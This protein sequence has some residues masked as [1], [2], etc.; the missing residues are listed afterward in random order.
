ML[1]SN[2]LN[3]NKE[4]FE[5]RYKEF[6]QYYQLGIPHYQDLAK[7]RLNNL[8]EKTEKRE[9]SLSG[10]LRFM[11]DIKDQTKFFT[12]SKMK[13]SR[14]LIGGR[15]DKNDRVYLK[16][17]GFSVDISGLWNSNIKIT[18]EKEYQK[19]LDKFGDDA[20]SSTKKD[21]VK[22]NKNMLDWKSLD[23]Y[24]D[25][26]GSVKSIVEFFFNMMMCYNSSVI[27]NSD[28]DWQ[29][30]ASS[31]WYVPLPQEWIK[32]K[33]ILDQMMDSSGNVLDNLKNW[34]IP[35]GGIVGNKIK[36]K[37][38]GIDGKPVTD[39]EQD[40]GY[41]AA[42]A[43]KLNLYN[44]KLP[45]WS[46]AQITDETNKAYYGGAFFTPFPVP[47]KLGNFGYSYADK[48]I[49]NLVAQIQNTQGAGGT[50][51]FF[52]I[53]P[54][55]S[56]GETGNTYLSGYYG[57]RYRTI[58]DI[59]YSNAF[60]TSL[61]NNFI[62]SGGP[63]LH[64]AY[65]SASGPGQTT[66]LRKNEIGG[67][68]SV[69][70]FIPLLDTNKPEYNDYN[71][72]KY[73]I[74]GDSTNRTNFWYSTARNAY[75]TL[76]L[77]T[78]LSQPIGSDENDYEDAIKDNNI[79]EIGDD[80]LRYTKER[81]IANPTAGGPMSNVFT[82]SS[83]AKNIG[84][85]RDM[86]MTFLLSN[87]GGYEK[88]YNQP[89]L[90]PPGLLRCRGV[91]KVTN[92]DI[93][94]IKDNTPYGDTI[95]SE[96]AIIAIV[97]RFAEIIADK[98]KNYKNI[99]KN[100]WKD[101]FTYRLS[102]AILMVRKTLFEA[103]IMK[104]FLRDGK[105]L[106]QFERMYAKQPNSNKKTKNGFG[107]LV[108]GQ[109]GPGKVSSQLWGGRGCVSKTY[110]GLSNRDDYSDRFTGCKGQPLTL[111][112]TNEFR[113]AFKEMINKAICARFLH[114][115]EPK[116][117]DS[118]EVPEKYWK[119]DKFVAW[120]QGDCDRLVKLDVSSILDIRIL[121]EQGSELFNMHEYLRNALDSEFNLNQYNF[122]DAEAK[123][124]RCTAGLLQADPDN[125]ITF[126]KLQVYLKKAH[127]SK[128]VL[129][130]QIDRTEKKVK[131]E[132]KAEKLKL[133][134]EITGQVEELLRTSVDGL[135]Q[136]D[137]DK[138]QKGLRSV[139][140]LFFTK[141][142]K[143][144]SAYR[145]F[146]FKERDINKKLATFEKGIEVLGAKGGNINRLEKERLQLEREKDENQLKFREQYNAA[147]W[148]II[149]ILTAV[150]KFKKNIDDKSLFAGTSNSIRTKSSNE[151]QKLINE[152]NNPPV[153]DRSVAATIIKS[154]RKIRD[155]NIRLADIQEYKSDIQ[156][157]DDVNVD[158]LPAN[159]LAGESKAGI[160][161]VYKTRKFGFNSYHLFDI[162]SGRII[163]DITRK[164]LLGRYL[165]S[166]IK[167]R[168]FRGIIIVGKDDSGD[169]YFGFE[170]KKYDITKEADRKELK[171]YRQV[172]FEKFGEDNKYKFT[173]KESSVQKVI[174]ALSNYPQ[175]MDDL[176]QLLKS[177][178]Y[179]QCIPRSGLA[180]CIRL[181]TI[182]EVKEILDRIVKKY[183]LQDEEEYHFRKLIRSVD[184]F[185]TAVSGGKKKKTNR[186]IKKI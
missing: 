37:T 38:V 126:E 182:E 154:F 114:D 184:I 162:L 112:F 51:N 43:T 72:Y 171:K 44:W 33:G 100:A 67:F 160:W 136:N 12:D 99:E 138:V 107:N 158:P 78:Y 31:Q 55:S 24:Q 150:T 131:E 85:N 48:N 106:T 141:F 122:T 79:V 26:I 86:L 157:D 129:I 98:R 95:V 65:N 61:Q 35:L 75:N 96:E 57:N 53:D 11:N 179:K 168:V 147:R 121:D 133:I 104:E 82:D 142:T 181:K 36:I 185:P 9:E 170:P 27:T 16:E 47:I 130:D 69:D 19:M 89:D 146:A 105:Y 113:L 175:S 132:E 41:T 139:R 39:K 144:F 2:M 97:N 119:E 25:N 176:G 68:V 178:D 137:L 109:P 49:A 102:R 180:K 159:R 18:D 186:K 8:K 92:G 90:D 91:N 4:T 23:L 66:I 153:E 15:P 115:D 29:D 28:K 84:D 46:S 58:Y 135:Q 127:Q 64:I 83:K 123:Q 21:D 110:K 134:Q 116:M 118:S 161:I 165:L 81:N 71:I 183:G 167:N 30:P 163:P 54:K 63:H 60:N 120:C 152:I 34:G 148:Y 73:G 145:D 101:Q 70:G 128:R 103:P 169:W 7:E 151:F 14:N 42:I 108:I 76:V 74:F 88:K 125:Q 62:T 40:P 111:A 59:I 1:N 20:F 3:S 77:R 50:G 52:G 6:K 80:I 172:L 10:G 93:N 166:L 32:K 5:E 143:F 156:K 94:D 87:Y 117:I 45:G 13:D 56:I 174:Y 124:R 22:I 164:I 17:E 149:L 155:E 140:G 173:D 177:D